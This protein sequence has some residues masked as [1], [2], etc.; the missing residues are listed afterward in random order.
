MRKRKAMLMK[1]S[2]ACRRAPSTIAALLLLSLSFAS[3]AVHAAPSGRSLSSRQA[4][5][6]PKGLAFHN[7]DIQL[8]RLTKQKFFTGAVLVARNGHVLFSKGYG[9][10][11][12]QRHIRNT[13][14]TQFRIGTSTNQFTAMAILQ[15][16]AAGKLHVQDRVCQYVEPCPKAWRPIA[17]HQLLTHTSGM[18]DFPDQEDPTKPATP[19]Q[20]LRRAERTPLI[21]KPGSSWSYSNLGYVVL[22][23]VIEKVSGISY[24]SFL[25]NHIFLPAHLSHSGYNDTLAKP[26]HLAVGYQDAFTRSGYIDMSNAFSSAGVYSSVGDLFRWD[27]ALSKATVASRAVISRM[28]TPYWTLCRGSCPV[29]PP[30]PE[31][32]YRTAV[33]RA[34]YGYGWAI[35]NLRGT[36]HRL[37]AA[38]GGFRGAL[39]YNGRYPDDKA[40]IIVLTNEDDIDMDQVVQMLQNAVLNNK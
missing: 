34:S 40:V 1:H 4:V 26:Q 12:R 28:F 29:P 11:D 32:N 30:Q 2:T 6:A 3:Q 8:T 13:T 22:G 17:L 14:A 24:G 39:Q 38:A 35:A 7:V 18:A 10:A 20:L 27:K 36:H 31:W 23:Y 9:M 33:S 37:F 15:L 5:A 16:E 21:A 25:R 19:S